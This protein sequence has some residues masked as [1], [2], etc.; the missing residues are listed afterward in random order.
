MNHLG[1]EFNE[2]IMNEAVKGL[3]N[4]IRKEGRK[5]GNKHSGPAWEKWDF[6]NP[7]YMYPEKYGIMAYNHFNTNEHTALVPSDWYIDRKGR[8]HV[9]PEHTKYDSKSFQKAGSDAVLI[10]RKCDENGKWYSQ[11]T[12]VIIDFKT[13]NSADRRGYC[14]LEF[15]EKKTKNGEWSNIGIFSEKSITS[16]II[17]VVKDKMYAVK[18]EDLKELSKHP[19]VKIHDNSDL[20]R[21]KHYAKRTYRIP[22]YLLKSKSIISEDVKLPKNYFKDLKAF[23][24]KAWGDDITVLKNH[25]YKWLDSAIDSSPIY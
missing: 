8:T 24:K 20:S 17:Y 4:W 11:G 12:K 10:T 3:K 25:D 9:H 5:I 1:R 13:Q 19:S 14:D 6:I 18:V 7:L 15:E 23:I 16:I 21:E 22:L 2:A